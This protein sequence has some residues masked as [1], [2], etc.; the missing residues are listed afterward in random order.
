M[1]TSAIKKQ[2]S[3]C[4]SI[5]LNPYMVFQTWKLTSEIGVWNHGKKKRK[6]KAILSLAYI[7]DVSCL[8]NHPFYANIVFKDTIHT[9]FYQIIFTKER[10]RE[11]KA[12]CWYF[13]DSLYFPFLISISAHHVTN[14]K[15]KSPVSFTIC[16]FVHY[17]L[18]NFLYHISCLY[19]VLVYKLDTTTNTK[20]LK[21]EWKPLITLWITRSAILGFC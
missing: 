9:S 20:F 6:R 4:C 3:D 11:E 7:A 18:H 12:C 5:S 16:H 13:N 10:T 1:F 19:S 2:T 21:A 8:T 14:I 15:P 17:S